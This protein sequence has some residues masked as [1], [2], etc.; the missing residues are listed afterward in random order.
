MSGFSRAYCYRGPP[1]PPPAPCCRGWAGSVSPHTLLIAHKQD[2]GIQINTNYPREV[3][4]D[5]T[6]TD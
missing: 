3:L 5:I 1:A 2:S 4:S 6:G